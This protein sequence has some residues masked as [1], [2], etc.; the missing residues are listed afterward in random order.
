VQEPQLSK[1]NETYKL[2]KQTFIT[3]F[4]CTWRKPNP[5]LKYMFEQS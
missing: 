2:Q 5:R 3:G 4:M 1:N